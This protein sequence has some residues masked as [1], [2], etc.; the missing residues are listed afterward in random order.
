MV[1]AFTVSGIAGGEHA[2]GSWHYDGA[3]FDVTS[4]NGIPVSADNAYVSQ[5]MPLA[6]QLGAGQV[7]GPGDPG[8]AGHVHIAW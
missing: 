4:I 1:F 2:R 5:F 8:H 7:Y 6:R 3:G